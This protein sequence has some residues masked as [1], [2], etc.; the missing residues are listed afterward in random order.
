M[1]YAVDTPNR[2]SAMFWTG[3]QRCLKD[4][5]TVHPNQPAIGDVFAGY[6]RCLAPAISDAVYRLSQMQTTFKASNRAGFGSV[7]TRARFNGFI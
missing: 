1:E 7:N 5:S 2:L 3:Y 4:L 6:Q